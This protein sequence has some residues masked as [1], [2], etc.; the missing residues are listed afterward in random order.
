[1]TGFP[2][3]GDEPV[4][5]VV[6][7]VSGSGKSTVA[8]LLA[9]RLG[10]DFTDGDDL[11][12]PENVAKMAAG[13]PLTD[14]D[15]EPW[16]V[17]V[18]EWIRERT[19]AGRPGLITCSALKRTYRDRLRGEHVIF[20][21]LAGTRAEIKRRL[22]ARN[23]HFMPS[24]LLESQFATLEEPGAGERAIT[25]DISANAMADAERIVTALGLHAAGASRGVAT[26]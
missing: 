1:M 25:V 5:L 20:V 14:E 19:G 12:P 10:W 7:G 17:K 3:P 24:S 4:V 11:H 15:R 21:Y 16:L 26:P 22:A 2:S 9:A 18:A 6:M 23:G 8:G 13:H